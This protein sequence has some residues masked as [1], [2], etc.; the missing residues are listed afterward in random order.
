MT[1]KYFFFT[2]F[3]NWKNDEICDVTE[4]K[5]FLMDPTCTFSFFSLF[6]NTVPYYITE[7]FR[8]FTV[9][10]VNGNSRRETPIRLFILLMY[11]LKLFEL[12][13]FDSYHSL[14]FFQVN[15]SSWENEGIKKSKLIGINIS[16]TRR[17]YDIYYKWIYLKI[18]HYYDR[19][20]LSHCAVHLQYQYW[21]IACSNWLSRIDQNAITVSRLPGKA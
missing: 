13:I 2:V 9:P 5:N 10:A 14:L 21:T 3:E 7:M 11:R 18:L 8:V 4:I 12:W 19:P 17:M 16:P 15:Y 6:F 20:H 1:N